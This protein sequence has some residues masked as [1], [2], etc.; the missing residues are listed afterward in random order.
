MPGPH[1]SYG[2]FTSPTAVKSRSTQELQQ[3]YFQTTSSNAYTK[4]NVKISPRGRHDNF[5]HIHNIGNTATKWM[6]FQYKQAPLL[7]K[8]SCMYGKDFY[9]KPS[10]YMECKSMAEHFKG[11]RHRINSLPLLETMSQ[12]RHSFVTPSQADLLK[13]TVHAT[14]PGYQKTDTIGGTNFSWEKK[15]QAHGIYRAPPPLAQGALQKAP[16]DSLGISG[17][18]SSAI[19]QSSYRNHCSDKKFTNLNDGIKSKMNHQLNVA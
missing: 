5:S 13:G 4:E 17:V 7:G 16:L 12:Q 14:G 11:S 18:D 10:D 3:L 8:D 2:C 1:K 9:T 19:W 15:S 6:P